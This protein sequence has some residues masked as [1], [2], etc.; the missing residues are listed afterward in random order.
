MV[1]YGTRILPARSE[2][3]ILLYIERSYVYMWF[4]AMLTRSVAIDTR[5]FI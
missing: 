5:S 4:A 3:R 2:L 1:S